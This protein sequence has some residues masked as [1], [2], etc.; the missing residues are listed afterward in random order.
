MSLVAGTSG[1]PEPNLWAY[2]SA[3]VSSL[4]SS[5]TVLGSYSTGQVQIGAIGDT[6]RVNLQHDGKVETTVSAASGASALPATPVGYLVATI[7]GANRKIPCY[8]A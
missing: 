4:G 7:D 8:A 3:L 2:G 5:N 1:T 6:T